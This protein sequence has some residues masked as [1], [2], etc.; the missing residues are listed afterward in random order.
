MAGGVHYHPVHLNTF[1]G[2]TASGVECFS[3]G[4]SGPSKLAQL[5]IIG[6]V[7]DSEFSAGKGDRPDGFGAEF[8]KLA[9]VEIGA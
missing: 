8:G 3:T 7:D 9:R 4:N 1:S 6:C 5:V 2:M